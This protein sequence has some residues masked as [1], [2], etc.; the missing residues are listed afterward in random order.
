MLRLLF[1][2][3]GHIILTKFSKSCSKLKILFKNQNFVQKLNV[4]SRVEN[5]FKKQNFIQEKIRVGIREKI[6]VGILVSLIF[7]CI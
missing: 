3:L 5:L 1:L 7:L 2:L 6:R 4:W